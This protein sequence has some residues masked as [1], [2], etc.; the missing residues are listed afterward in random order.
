MT[1][2]ADR[3]RQEG[4]PLVDGD[5]V[6]FVW[7]G[8][9]P[10]QLVGDWNRW[11]LEGRPLDLVEESPG[12]W[13]AGLTL[14]PD[15]Y[16]EYR[17]VRDGQTVP[18]PLN[19]RPP[20]PALGDDHEY[21][22]MPG[23][24]ETALIRSARGR[25]GKVTRREVT[26]TYTIA[27]PRCTVW[28]YEPPYSGPIPLIVVLDGQDYLRRA[29]LATIV[30]N[31][32]DA[33]RIEPVGLAMV[34]SAGQ[35]RHV[36]YACNDATVGFLKN[37]VVPLAAS[38]INLSDPTPDTPYA[39]LGASMGGLMSL[40]AALRLPD[41]FGKVIS[42]SGAF[43]T[44]ILHHPLVVDDLV[45]HLSCPPIG[46][47]ASIDAVTPEIKV[48]M[49]CGRYEWLLEPNRDMYHHL[50]GRGVNVT[51]TE[52]SGGHNWTAWRNHIASGLESMFGQAREAPLS[53]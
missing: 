51:F 23:A 15:A 26:G 44:S 38:H 3:A 10:P 2:I 18:D 8:D 6:T 5:T 22:W 25:R 27:R 32:S 41:L 34:Q 33:E 31:L 36:E 11:G 13:T 37:H 42:Q 7:L 50:A 9:H 17:F 29:R 21:L 35:A 28:L 53:P 47:P 16:L 19:R 40:Y 30:D 46:E 43:G 12:I 52:F 48:W 49:D 14:A 24:S 4:T 39:I 20:V 45:D 1:T